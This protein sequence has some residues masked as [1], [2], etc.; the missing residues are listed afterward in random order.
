[1]KKEKII[2]KES[3]VYIK[4]CKKKDERLGPPTTKIA[5]FSKNNNTNS[6]L[7]ISSTIL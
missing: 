1:M 4:R 7:Y 6:L 3:K 5:H 2:V